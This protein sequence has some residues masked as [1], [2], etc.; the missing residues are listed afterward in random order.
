M[1]QSITLVKYLIPLDFVWGNFT[2]RGKFLRG[3]VFEIAFISKSTRDLALHLPV[4]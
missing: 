1:T 4:L 2:Y 3:L